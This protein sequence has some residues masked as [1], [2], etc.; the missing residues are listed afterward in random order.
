MKDD[1][2]IKVI[3][4][5]EDWQVE[6]EPPPRKVEPGFS[7]SFTLAFP[8]STH[9]GVELFPAGTTLYLPIDGGRD[10]AELARVWED[11]WR[12]RPFLRERPD[13][14]LVPIQ[15]RE[16]LRMRKSKRLYD[17]QC[18]IIGVEQRFSSLN[19]A[20]SHA[21]CRWTTVEAGAVNVFERVVFVDQ[22]RL[23]AVKW[24]REHRIGGTAFPPP[25]EPA[26]AQEMLPGINPHAPSEA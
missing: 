8:K 18:E 2:T 25:P 5:G 3:W 26:A 12:A 21:L 20:A 22:K 7:V 16:A 6:C 4:T 17:C 1:I 23:L 10:D 14:Y 13:K 11:H 24:M 9:E 15:L 19:A